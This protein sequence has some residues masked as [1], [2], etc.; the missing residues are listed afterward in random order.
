MS[1]FPICCV[2]NV[3]KKGGELCPEDYCRQLQD[4]LDRYCADAGQPPCSPVPQMVNDKI[5]YCCCGRFPECCVVNVGNQGGKLCSWDF[6]RLVQEQVNQ[7]CWNT[8]QPPCAPVPQAE[9]GEPCWCCCTSF[10]FYNA[11]IEASP[12]EHVMAQDIAAGADRILAG[13]YHEGD[14]APAWEPRAVDYAGSLAADGTADEPDFDYMYYVAY[15]REDGSEPPRFILATVDHLFLRPSGKLKPIQRLQPDDRLVNAHGGHSRVIFTVPARFK[16]GLHHLGFDG[17]DNKTLDHHLLSINGVVT[18][19]Y[20]VQLAYSNGELDLELVDI[21]PA[22]EPPGGWRDAVPVRSAN[23]AALDFIND[24]TRWPAGMTPR[25]E[26][27][28][29]EKA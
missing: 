1:E 6:C 13:S 10:F 23:P 5:C 29:E 11:P 12:G 28:G 2:E 16:G 15:Q 8:H 22:P 4:P 27:I 19:D 24:K 26:S 18:A 21:P 7:Y 14:E 3:G 20:A 25:A 9:N 17:F